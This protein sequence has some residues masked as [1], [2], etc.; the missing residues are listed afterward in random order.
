MRVYGTKVTRLTLWT[1]CC[2][3][4]PTGTLPSVGTSGRVVEVSRGRSSRTNLPRP[5]LVGEAWTGFSDRPEQMRATGYDQSV[6]R[7][8][9]TEGCGAD[10]TA[11]AAYGLVRAMVREEEAARLPP[12]R[13]L[14]SKASCERVTQYG[15]YV[16]HLNLEVPPIPGF[17]QLQGSRDL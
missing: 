16:Q 1:V 10:R 5:G 13:L 12:P 3:R 11:T 8:T 15:C 4:L 9:G 17:K 7:M 14:A 6:L 2:P